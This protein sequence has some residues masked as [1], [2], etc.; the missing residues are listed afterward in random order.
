MEIDLGKFAEGKNMQKES[1]GGISSD[2]SPHSISWLEKI[3]SIN[4]NNLEMQ[5]F[6]DTQAKVRCQ[7]SVMPQI[8]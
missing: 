4:W 5:K 1:N 6:M 3:N 8:F 7:M 2:M